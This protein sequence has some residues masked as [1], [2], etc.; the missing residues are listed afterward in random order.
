MESHY[1]LWRSPFTTFPLHHIQDG[2]PNHS[3][4]TNNP[5]DGSIV[6][7]KKFTYRGYAIK[8]SKHKVMILRVLELQKSQKQP[9]H[10]LHN[11]IIL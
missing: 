4:V 11:L 5:T 10:L 3:H 1:L 7:Q 9:S 6:L 2:I 8:L